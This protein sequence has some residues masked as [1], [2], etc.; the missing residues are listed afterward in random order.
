MTRDPRGSPAA[1]G[2]GGASSAPST[3]H[4]DAGSSTPARDGLEAYLCAL[5]SAEPAPGGGSAAAV[6]GALGAA[7]AAMVCRVTA[8]RDPGASPLA[9]RAAELDAARRRLAALGDDDARAYAAVIAA[10]RAPE[11]GRADAV[12]A[13]LLRATELPVQ[14]AAEAANIVEACADITGPARASALSDLHVAGLLAHA[15]LR[16]AVATARVNVAGIADAGVAGEIARRLDALASESELGFR[17]L[18]AALGERGLR[19]A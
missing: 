8:A 17:R 6:A 2:A 14:L 19:A 1:R 12:Q 10:R 7:L 18:E 3:G 9:A 13:A 16:A 5:A 11:P 4:A 15:S